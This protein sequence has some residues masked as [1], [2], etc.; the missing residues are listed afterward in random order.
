MYSILYR[1]K[2]DQYVRSQRSGTFMHSFDFMIFLILM[3]M[4]MMI[5]I[6]III[7]IITITSYC[8]AG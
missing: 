1:Q 6:V 8:T 4:K 7:I 5:I 3:I 2:N